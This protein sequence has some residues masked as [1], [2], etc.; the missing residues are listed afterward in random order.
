MTKIIFLQ[1]SKIK[2]MKTKLTFLLLT[3]FVVKMS[4]CQISSNIISDNYKLIKDNIKA[5]IDTLSKNPENWNKLLD[6]AE[7]L[8]IKKDSSYGEW[9]NNLNLEFKTLQ[10]QNST[11][12]SLGL[13]YSLNLEKA[14]I[15]N[16]GYLRN[17]KSIS[18][19]SIGNIA[20]NNQVNP[21]NF[22]NLKLS[23]NMFHNGGGVVISEM[24]KDLSHYASLRKKLFRIEK[25]KI[26]SSIEWNELKQNFIYKDSWII[27]YDINVGIES[28][29][30]FSRTQYTGGIRFG[31]GY[32]SWD[33]DD[34]LS[35]INILDWPFKWIRNATGYDGS[36]HSGITIPS[37]FFG[38]D[39]VNFVNDTIRENIEGELKPFPRFN[40]GIGF[41]TVLS[42]VS[43]QTLYFNNSF[44][45]Y[46]EIS[47]SSKIV[48]NDY[49]KYSYFVASI[50]SSNG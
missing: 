28:N 43:N 7:K 8:I 35:K 37:L 10:N 18:F 20:F 17:G 46:K 16:N 31:T 25:D 2:F 6:I 39:Y 29:Q 23:I 44:K 40:I 27:K 1:M 50:T 42:Q 47:A 32:K 45:Y 38:L 14:W 48:E 30:D 11:F 5:K 19:E 13:S 24:A 3:I 21:Y 41:R 12:S 49:D 36:V 9:F 33:K 26:R 15:K 4:F 34:V 22:F